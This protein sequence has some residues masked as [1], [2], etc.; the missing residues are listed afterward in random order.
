METWDT[1][2]STLIQLSFL[3]PL[4]YSLNVHKF[5]YQPPLTSSASTLK[6]DQWKKE[7]PVSWKFNLNMFESLK[8]ELAF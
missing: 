6:T 8:L 1:V 5:F 7:N 4:G 2:M 3:G